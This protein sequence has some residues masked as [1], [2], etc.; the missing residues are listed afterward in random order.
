MIGDLDTEFVHDY[1]VVLRKIRSVLSLFKGVYTKQLTDELKAKFSE[2]MEPTGRLRDLDVYLL[3]KQKFYDLLPQSQHSGLALM[4]KLFAE[5]RVTEITKLVR[6]LHSKSYKKEISRLEKLFNKPEKL[7]PGP[8]A[9]MRAL[10][11][12]SALIWKRY[13][14]VRKTADQLGPETDDA[15]V[16]ALRIHCK[17]LRYLMEF[18]GP[19]FPKSEFKSLIK[20]LKQLQDALGLF[21]DCSVQQASLQDFLHK[22]GDWPNVV[23]LAVAQSVGALTAVLHHRQ[24]EQRAKV[25]ESFAQFNEPAMQE[26]FR[27][28]F[29][30]REGKK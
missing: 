19:V 4:F 15:E 12:A 10:D 30:A 23:S 20:P 26:T 17:K 21:N 13:S 14:L 22:G 28:L 8:K 6:H 3:E 16:H 5:Q 24:I 27:N 29:H 1:R 2:M 7:K 9:D 18:F 11:Y 25:I